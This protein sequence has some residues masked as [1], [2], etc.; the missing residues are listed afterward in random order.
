MSV[1]TLSAPPLAQPA[2]ARHVFTRQALWL[3]GFTLAVV[4]FGAVVRITG[5]GAGCGRHWPTCQGEIAHLPKRIETAIELSHRVST[6][7]DMLLVFALSVRAFRLFEKGHP[8][9]RAFAAASAM[10]VVEALV[11]AALVLLSLVGMDA[12][13]RRAIVMPIHLL[14]TSGLVA[15]L[16]LGAFYS[17]PRSGSP[18][19][20]APVRRSV[21]RAALA[22]LVVSASGALT[23]LGDTVY[24]VKAGEMGSRLLRDHEQAAHFLERL[25]IVHPLLAVGGA[26]LVLAAG[27][28]ALGES[29]S[30]LGRKLAWFCI[31]ACLSQVG[32]GVLN[33]MLS[34]PGW[35]QVVHLLV[36]NAVWLGL[37]LLAAELVDSRVPSLGVGPPRTSPI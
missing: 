35:M 16:A 34:A 23:A 6:G 11:G 27:G 8:S 30:V 37:V 2:N 21:L 3:L 4:L 18:S 19:A 26:V 24:P 14:V 22:V 17:L 20:S 13:L 33:I 36:A 12:S 10:M 31:G 29:K 5:S 28:A 15:A 9:R 7:L 25:R 32:L 1:Q